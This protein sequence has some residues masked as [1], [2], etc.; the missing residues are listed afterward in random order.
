MIYYE[1]K[2]AD[3]NNLDVPSTESACSNDCPPLTF[4]NSMEQI[5][6]PND[7]IIITLQPTSD[8]LIKDPDS[9]PGPESNI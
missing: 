6:V 1:L 2:L 3:G 5:K 7:S 4:T 9:I 8:A